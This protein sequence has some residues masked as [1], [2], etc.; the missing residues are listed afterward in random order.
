MNR[1]ATCLLAVVLLL[2]PPVLAAEQAEPTLTPEQAILL[3]EWDRYTDTLKQAGR[4]L[5]QQDTGNP[6]DTAEGFRYLALLSGLAAERIQYY[7]NPTYPVL[8]RTLDPYRKIGLDSADNT[9]RTAS[10]EPGGSYVIRGIRGD[11]TYL[12]FQFNE[13]RAAV[14]N[15]NDS[16]IQFEADGSFEIY[17]TPERRGK[18]WLALPAR[19]DNFYLREIFID[20]QRERPSTVWLERLDLSLPPPPLTAATVAAQFDAMSRYIGDNLA[21]WHGYV[22]RNRELMHNKLPPPRTTTGE[23]GSE[24]NQY[25]GG[26]YDLA[27]D[28]ALVI[29]VDVVPGRFWNAQLG[30][31]WFQSLDYQYRQGSLNNEQVAVDT[32]GKVRLVIAHEDPGFANWL[33]TGGHREGIMFLRWNLARRTPGQPLVSLVKFA[34]LARVLPDTSRRL[35]AEQRRQVL[36]A[37]YSA[38]ARRFAQ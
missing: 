28:E 37:R 3:A 13:G 18:N 25:S 9:Y 19:A 15:L 11:S 22:S 34:D 38:V 29:E 27:S 1:L 5:I 36:Q 20:W 10:F 35:S 33:D 8:A 14:A 2:A 32:D 7:Q 26:Y 17:L 6:L 16:E 23:G 24:D 4:L 31:A 12:G 30:N 21:L